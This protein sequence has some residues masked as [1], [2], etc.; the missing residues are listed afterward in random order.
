MYALPGQRMEDLEADLAQA[1]GLMPPHLSVY[2]LTLEPNTYFA[3]FPP[4]VPDEDLAYAMLDRIT[5][6]TH[7]AGFERYEVSAYAKKG[8]RCWHNVN[9][10]QFGD[11]LG[12]GA[13]A[14]GKLSFHDRIE[15]FMRH[16]QPAAYLKAVAEGLPNQ[17]L[18]TIERADLPFE[19]MMN[20]LRLT[21]GFESRLFAERTGL[22]LHRIEPQLKEAEARGLIERSLTHIRPTELGQRF[23]NDL[24]TLF[25][26]EGS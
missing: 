25:L 6:M 5:E 12:I 2:H 21:E 18:H 8:H 19:F 16:K 9:Y 14:H 20:L 10:W 3:K 7:G 13:G 26:T 23:L 15:R 4:Q 24:L 17:T 1:Q 22:T 11:Y